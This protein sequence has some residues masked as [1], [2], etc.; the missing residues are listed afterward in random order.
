MHYFKTVFFSLSALILQLLTGCATTGDLNFDVK[1]AEIP[2]KLKQLVKDHRDEILT[3]ENRL[4]LKP[5]LKVGYQYRM[6]T[7][8]GEGEHDIRYIHRLT[9]SDGTFIYFSQVDV[10]GRQSFTNDSR[11]QYGQLS[12]QQRNERKKI[13]VQDPPVYVMDGHHECL[14]V[15]GKCEYV[16]FWGKPQVIETYYKDGVWISEES[17]NRKRKELV[18]RIYKA[19]GLPFYEYTILPRGSVIEEKRVDI[20]A[21]YGKVFDLKMARKDMP[22]AFA[23]CL[24]SSEQEEV[25]IEISLWRAGEQP[26]QRAFMVID[27]LEEFVT[28][29]PCLPKLF[30]A[31]TEAVK[32]DGWLLSKPEGE[33]IIDRINGGITAYSV[34]SFSM[35]NFNNWR[36]YTSKRLN[37]YFSPKGLRATIKRIE[38]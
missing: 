8:G 23:V 24:E 3:P 28:S 38:N 34:S 27:Q 30:G 26:T 9:K 11:Y 12:K 18:Y 33:M 37:D 14:F 36:T 20:D 21:D 6:V 1:S 16:D 35:G 5:N 2:D 10:Y 31:K 7:L 4:K 19:D 17:F 29:D 25:G 32:G 13:I 22:E 15:I